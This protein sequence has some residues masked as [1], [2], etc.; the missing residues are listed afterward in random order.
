MS[1]NIFS[2]NRRVI[3]IIALSILL[4]IVVVVLYMLQAGSKSTLAKKTVDETLSSIATITDTNYLD[5]ESLSDTSLQ[6][7]VPTSIAPSKPADT[8]TLS[9]ADLTD[10]VLTDIQ[11]IDTTKDFSDV[12][13][14]ISA[15]SK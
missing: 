10:S 9:P 11:S 12:N 13:I 5:D 1:R 14:D 3:F 6:I 15:L 8:T 4:L 7:S 2:K